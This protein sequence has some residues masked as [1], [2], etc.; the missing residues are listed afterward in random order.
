MNSLFNMNN[1]NNVD[2]DQLIH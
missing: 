1:D 2:I